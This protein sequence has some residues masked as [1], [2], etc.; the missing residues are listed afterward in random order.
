MSMPG[1][2]NVITQINDGVHSAGLGTWTN[3]DG[4]RGTVDQNY[5]EMPIFRHYT[6]NTIVATQFNLS[7]PSPSAIKGIFVKIT[8]HYSSPLYMYVN[9]I[10]LMRNGV[11]IGTAKVG[12]SQEFGTTNSTFSFGAAS[13]VWDADL[14]AA[15]VN[16]DGFGVA[17][18][19]GSDDTSE[20]VY[21]DSVQII[22]AYL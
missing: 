18:S 16:T 12:P 21:L 2:A 1:Y 7:I 6:G 10:Q 14:E 11:P 9:K 15:D 13:D 8:G 19:F 5:A 17:I 22:V 3:L 20:T 4:A